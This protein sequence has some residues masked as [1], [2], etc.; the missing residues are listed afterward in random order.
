MYRQVKALISFTEETK[1]QWEAI[2][3]EDETP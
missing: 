2:I 1:F 3:G